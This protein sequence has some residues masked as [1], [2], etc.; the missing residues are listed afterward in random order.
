MWNAGQS[1]CICG[2]KKLGSLSLKTN[3]I[4]LAFDF[5]KNVYFSS[6]NITAGL[7]KPLLS[8]GIGNVCSFRRID[9][10][11]SVLMSG[12]YSQ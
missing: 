7:R 10:K 8:W 9:E 6:S 12:F 5:Q 4:S 3:A 11:V 1:I 2:I